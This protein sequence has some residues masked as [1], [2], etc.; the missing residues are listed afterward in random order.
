MNSIKN[1]IPYHIAGSGTSTEGLVD[2]AKEYGIGTRVT[3]DVNEARKAIEEGKVIIAGHG[4]GIFTRFGHIM[5]YAGLDENG[6][7][8]VNN[9]NGGQQ[10]HLNLETV[11]SDFQES[12]GVAVIP[13]GEVSNQRESKSDSE[14][15]E[16]DPNYNEIKNE[17]W[18]AAQF[19]SQY[20]QEK[21]GKTKPPEW[22]YAQWAFETGNFTS[23]LTKYNKNLGGLTQTEPNGEENKQPDGGNYYKKYNT[24]EEYAR[25]YV[26]GFVNPRLRPELWEY[27]NEDFQ[28]HVQALH[29]TGYFESSPEEYYAGASQY[30]N[31]HPNIKQ[32]DTVE[33]PEQFYLASENGIKNLFNDAI[34]LLHIEDKKS[35]QYHEF[36]ARF[37][38]EIDMAETQNDLD[39]VNEVLAS[40][41]FMIRIFP[42]DDF[43]VVNRMKMGVK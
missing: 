19:A 42:L 13:T 12:G 33:F 5:T 34:Q 24:I 15:V 35:I 22:I 32:S 9:P 6:N 25:D 40:T 26:D 30:L 38:S 18:K 31:D 16:N 39:M 2:V 4:P 7:L 37:F 28:S 3:E 20:M 43:Y 29:D 21:Y 10:E 36:A 11:L 27:G 23:D 17:A 8:V 41:G 1:C 14:S